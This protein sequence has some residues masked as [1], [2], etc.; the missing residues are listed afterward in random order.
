MPRRESLHDS[1]LFTEI[2]FEV[3]VSEL[4]YSFDSVLI[5]LAKAVLLPHAVC[6]FGHLTFVVFKRNHSTT[7]LTS[8]ELVVLAQ[9]S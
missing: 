4:G 3:L 7:W 2:R 8:G 9:L 1:S 5:K 6:A